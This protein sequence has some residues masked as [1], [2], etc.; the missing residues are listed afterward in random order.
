MANHGATYF[1]SSTVAAGLSPTATV[2]FFFF[3]SPFL[4]YR[5]LSPA[6]SPS[7]I[8]PLSFKKVSTTIAFTRYLLIVTALLRRHKSAVYDRL[9]GH[10]AVRGIPPVDYCLR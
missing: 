6:P 8:P 3:F 1:T 7:F 4:C 2:F 10:D 5:L 9:S